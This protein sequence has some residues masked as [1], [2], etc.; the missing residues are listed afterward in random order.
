[1]GNNEPEAIPAIKVVVDPGQLSAP[2]GAVYV[3]VAPH[4]PGSL[5]SV[6]LAGQEIVGFS[7]SLIVT[8]KEH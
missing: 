2:V 4:T 6:M 8:L 5:L 3:T 1:M 7:V